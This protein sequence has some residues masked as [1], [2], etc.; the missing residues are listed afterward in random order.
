MKI[1]KVILGVALFAASYALPG[2]LASEGYT[3][4]VF[5]YD[6]VYFVAQ[7]VMKVVAGSL[8]FWGLVQGWMDEEAKRNRLKRKNRKLKKQLKAR[9]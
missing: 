6:L 5:G 2:W 9:R 7:D 3:Y 8:V 1:K 4:V